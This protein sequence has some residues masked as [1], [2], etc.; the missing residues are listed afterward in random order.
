MYQMGVDY[1]GIKPRM[2]LSK[3]DKKIWEIFN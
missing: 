1:I 3:F 2:Q